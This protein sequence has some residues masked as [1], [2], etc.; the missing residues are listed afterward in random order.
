[1]GDFDVEGK[2]IEPKLVVLGETGV[3]K[4]SMILRFKKGSFSADSSVATIGAAYFS[5]GVQVKGWNVKLQIWDTAGQERFRSMGSLY[6]RNAKAAILVYDCTEKKSLSILDKMYKTLIEHVSDDVILILA[7]NKCDA[8]K[9]SK[10]EIAAAQEKAKDLGAKL[11]FTSAKTGK[12]INEV[13]NYVA[14]ASLEISLNNS[15]LNNGGVGVKIED[16]SERGGCC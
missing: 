16:E 1:M 15:S 7:G 12:G 10:G 2:Y 14:R 9:L 5:K 3:G 4:T 13:F 8:A 6:Y 11:F